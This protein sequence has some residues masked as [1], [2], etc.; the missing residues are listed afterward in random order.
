MGKIEG[1]WQ[2]RKIQITHPEDDCLPR[3]K[4]RVLFEFECKTK[5]FDDAVLFGGFKFYW[6]FIGDVMWKEAIS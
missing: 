1:F 2:S 5:I 6:R 3:E 4:R